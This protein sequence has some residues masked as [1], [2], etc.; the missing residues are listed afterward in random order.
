MN[1][2]S[3]ILAETALWVGIGTMVYDAFKKEPRLDPSRIIHSS[4]HMDPNV[5]RAAVCRYCHGTW[6]GD[7]DDTYHARLEDYCPRR[8]AWFDSQ[9][10]WHQRQ[11]EKQ[12]RAAREKR[13]RIESAKAAK[14]AERR[15][16]AEHARKEQEYRDAKRV[17]LNTKTIT[18]D[19]GL[20]RA[21]IDDTLNEIAFKTHR[22]AK[23]TTH[24]DQIDTY[25]R[26]RDW[27]TYW[28][29]TGVMMGVEPGTRQVFC[30][31]TKRED[32]LR[33]AT[34]WAKDIPILM[35]EKD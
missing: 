19:G 29:I 3:K 5:G 31:V 20:F 6:W 22:N 33:V 25:S 34:T 26:I 27:L 14:A 4:H 8:D 1:K 7:K 15:R 18:T 11:R 16:I 10:E 35:V 12:E 9:A 2:H 24:D 32:L 28:E 30:G 21:K 17:W 13:E 23:P